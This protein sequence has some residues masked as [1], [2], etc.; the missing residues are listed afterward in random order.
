MSN[1]GFNFCDVN[2]VEELGLIVNSVKFPIT[3]EITENT[4][5]VPG[6]YG[7]INLGNSYGQKV[8]QIDITIPAESDTERISKYH[9]ISDL[10][11][12]FGSGEWPM[13]FTSDPDYTYYGHFSGVSVPEEIIPT[14]HWRTCT[15]TF[16]CSDPKGYGKYTTKNM[17]TNP[18]TI[19]PEG[20]SESSPIFT[21]MPKKEVKK[22]AISDEYGTYVYVGG[23]VDP[24]EGIT[25]IDNEPMVLNDPCNTLATWTSLTNSTVTFELDNGSIGGTMTST[26]NAIKVGVKDGVANFGKVVEDKWHGPCVQQWLTGSYTDYRIKVRMYNRQHYYRARGK[27]EV[28]LL[29][30]QGEKIGY[31]SLKDNGNS[32]EVKIRIVMYNGSSKLTLY[33]SYGTIKKGKTTTKTMKL[34]T[35]TKK[36]KEKGKTKTVQ[37]WKTVHLDED[38]SSSTFTDFYGYMTIEKIGNKFTYEIMK[39]DENSNPAWSKPIKKTVTD[40]TGKFSGALAGVA[41]YTCKYDISEDKADPIKEYVDNKMALSDLKVWNII[42]GGNSTTKKK[43]AEPVVIARPGDEVK[44][45]CEDRTI[46]KNGDVFMQRL[47]IGSDYPILEGGIPKTFAFEPDLSNAEWYLEYRPTIK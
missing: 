32:E 10:V 3:P 31:V 16:S 34:G 35:G 39:M 26:A 24:D 7:K 11:V 33:D 21:C 22:I 46:Y 36:V 25:P 17:K 15:L 43:A 27:C 18:I 19:V 37:Q 44:I 4:Q 23:E 1:F 12:T 8:F 30:N 9:D 5:D 40:K 20:R 6:M 2:V 41:F 47:Y 38:T 14:S 42:N 29:N 13:I 28:Y 45:N